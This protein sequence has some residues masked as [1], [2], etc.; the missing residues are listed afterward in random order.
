[1]P[2]L[3]NGENPKTGLTGLDNQKKLKLDAIDAETSAAILDG[4]DYVVEGETLH[5]SYDESDQQNFSDSANVAILATSGAAGLPESVTW[6]AYRD[7]TPE[8]GGELVRLTFGPADFLVLY[9][10]GA[11]AHKAAAMEAGGRRKASVMAAT[12]ADEVEQ[13]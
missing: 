6:N 9:T 10:A 5:F 13:A 7:W 1:M 3:E 4:F 11:L 2:R 8:Y 12:T